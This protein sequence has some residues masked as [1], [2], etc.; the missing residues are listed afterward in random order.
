MSAASQ[1]SETQ[2]LSGATEGFLDQPVIRR[3]RPRHPETTIIDLLR[4]GR[5]AIPGQF[6]SPPREPLGTLGWKQL[7]LAT[8]NGNWDLVLASPLRRCHDF[9]RLLAQRLE[10]DFEA[11]ERLAELDFGHWIGLGQQEIEQRYPEI[12]HHYYFQPR[13]FIAPGGESMEA[14]TQRIDAFWDDLLLRYRGRKILILT[15]TGVI[16][17]LICK[18]MDILYQRS[19]RFEIGYAGYTRFRVDPDGEIALV[20]HGFTHAGQLDEG[21]LPAPSGTTAATP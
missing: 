7:T 10:A 21:A 5:V 1:G 9:A 18:A 4:H 12:L 8:R 17:A 11:D 2:T 3:T 14:F 20:G 15:H 19:L 13:R 16:R 6:S